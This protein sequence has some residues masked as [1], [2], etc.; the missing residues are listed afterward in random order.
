M[1]SKLRGFM[2]PLVGG[3]ISLAIAAIVIAAV[4]IPIIKAQ[5]T[6]GWTTTETTVYGYVPLFMII[7][8]LIGSIGMGVY[9]MMK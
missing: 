9:G 1:Q 7:S 6:T 8:L 5:N 4:A 2:A 3:A